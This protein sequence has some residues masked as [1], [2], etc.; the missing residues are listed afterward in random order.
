MAR[1]GMD[2]LVPELPPPSSP[3]VRDAGPSTVITDPDDEAAYLYDPQALRSY[4]L[5]LSPQDL[6][7][8]DADPQAE[9]YVP[10]S[11]VFEGKEYGPVGIRYKGYVGSFRGCLAANGAK[12]CTK[13]SIKVSFN[14]QMPQVEFYG[15]RK[16]QFHAMNRDP[17]MLKERL[18]YS[19]FRQSGQAA[20]RAVHARL[21]INGALVGLFALVEQVDGRFTRSRFTE[22]GEG[23]LYKEAWPLDSTRQPVDESYLLSHLETNEN[24]N[25]SFATMLDFGA[26]LAAADLTA[27]SGAIEQFTDLDAVM[28]YVAIDRTIAHDDG[29][30]H[31]YCSGGPC[32]NH[33]YYWYQEATAARLWIIAWDLDGSFNLDNPVT[34]L[35]FAWD[36]TTLGCAPR[37]VPPAN[38]P[39][40]PPT[41]D[42][43]TLGWATMQQ[44]Y[45]DAVA[46]LLRGPLSADAVEP[47]LAEWEAQI[48]PFVEEAARAHADAVTMAQWDAA[49]SALRATIDL[50]RQRALTR[51]DSGIW[52]ITEPWNPR[53]PAI[54]PDAGA[55]DDG[56]A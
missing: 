28:R 54:V 37:F 56:G 40:M 24:E 35:A 39:L 45:L 29:P 14:W 5:R 8:L 47:A 53:R 36:D 10:G 50:L 2:A 33:N 11:L 46:E 18:G 6:A 42:K 43:L 38:Q 51:I 49:R 48:A 22:G 23:N 16:L 17:S 55:G 12:S 15:L 26:A 19:I 1:E 3:P 34:T 4:E 32:W 30:F 13:L 21:T 44:R 27:L 9:V 20:P 52:P 41:C 7:F 25:P 31:W